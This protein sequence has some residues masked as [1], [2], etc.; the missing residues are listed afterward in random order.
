[1]RFIK[2]SICGMEKAP[3]LSLIAFNNF[4]DSSKNT[5]ASVMQSKKYVN[6]YDYADTEN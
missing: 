3:S 2:A 1:M 5:E 4:S 6:K